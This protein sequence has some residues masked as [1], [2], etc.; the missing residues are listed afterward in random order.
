[1]SEKSEEL[2][3]QKWSL[4]EKFRLTDE[5]LEQNNQRQ[6][7]WRET[8]G[9]PTV[10]PQ[11]KARQRA[12]LVRQEYEQAGNTSLLPATQLSQLA[13]A[14]ATLGRFDKAADLAP[15]DGERAEYLE[16]WSAVWRD[17]SASCAHGDGHYY[18]ERDVFSVK[19]DA[20]AVIMRCNMCGF[21]NCVPLPAEIEDQRKKRR[22]A[23]EKFSGRHPL[24]VKQE[25]G[26]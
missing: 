2:F 11:H 15:T 12:L 24:E 9:V 23:R 20:D 7:E 8:L 10:S 19:L 16:F 18:A 22:A 14:Y 6:R 21:R 26:T 3:E 17:D 4:P 13:E 5:L 1:M 25:F